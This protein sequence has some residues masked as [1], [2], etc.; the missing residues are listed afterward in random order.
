MIVNEQVH[1]AGRLHSSVY[2]SLNFNAGPHILQH[3]TIPRVL[4]EHTAG[5]VVYILQPRR[6]IL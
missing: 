6:E 4:R 5:F 1:T 2:G 3:F